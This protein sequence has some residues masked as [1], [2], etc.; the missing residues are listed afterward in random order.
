MK[1]LSE[2]INLED[3]GFTIVKEWI[4]N[5]KYPIEILKRDKNKA[6]KELFNLQVTTRSPMGAIVYETG[7]ILVNNGWIRILGSGNKK[8]NRGLMEWNKGKTYTVLGEPL[9]YLL[10]ADDVVGGFFAINAGGISNQNLNKIFYFAPDTLNW[11]S[12]NIGYSDF[13]IFCF[14][15]NLN[16]F[17]KNMY[18][19][20]WENEIVSVNGNQGYSFYPF[21]WTNEGKC[22]NKVSRKAVPIEELWHLS[23][24]LK[25]QFTENND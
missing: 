10:I 11:E 16:E 12:L 1:E 21:L 7:G 5:G 14:Q 23:Q 3:P 8:M 20:N 24:D 9:P 22:I 4:A 6:D 19:D 15:G 13:L 17:Y 2:L 25:R 18:W